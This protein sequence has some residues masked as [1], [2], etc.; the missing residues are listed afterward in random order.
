M[1]TARQL[2]AL[3]LLRGV[4]ERLLEEL[5]THAEERHVEPG[6]AVVRQHEEARTRSSYSPVR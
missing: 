1:V 3:P 2:A 6:D 5:A 4:N